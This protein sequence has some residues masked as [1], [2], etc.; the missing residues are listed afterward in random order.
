MKGILNIGGIGHIIIKTITPI[1]T[2]HH[3]V[4]NSLIL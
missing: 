3:S 2:N 1:N 4:Q